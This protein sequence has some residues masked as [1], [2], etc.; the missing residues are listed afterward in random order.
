[1]RIHHSIRHVMLTLFAALMLGVAGAFG[2]YL[3]A[4]APQPAPP[5]APGALWLDLNI[6]PALIPWFNAIARPGD[7]A[8]ADQFSQVIW[9]NDVT[10]EPKVIVFKSAALAEQMVPRLAGKLQVLGYNLEHGP[11]NPADEQADPVDSI[12]RMRALADRYGLQLA[13]GPDHDFAL[14]HGA[15]M[16]PYVDIFVMQVQRV[17]T[18]PDVVREFVVPLAA[19]VRAANPNIATAI[20]IRTEGD[21]HALAQLVASLR[22]S[23]D[24][25]SIL[26][27]RQTTDVAQA[28]VVA[29]R[30]GATPAAAN[31]APP[32]NQAPIGH[33]S[34]SSFIPLSDPRLLSGLALGIIFGILLGIYVPRWWDNLPHG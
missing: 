30:P 25:V 21:V 28:L 1:M 23:I 13:L 29:L 2:P 24:G 8:R 6:Q 4:Q 32:S 14:S 3:T 11:L 31:A 34:D 5:D 20:Q 26:T 22:D 12:R 33:T 18:Q 27:S 17:Q 16:A 9:L 7:M 10:V 15:A 19:E